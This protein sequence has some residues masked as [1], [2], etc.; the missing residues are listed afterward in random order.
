[1]SLTAIQFTW[2]QYWPSELWIHTLKN[3]NTWCVTLSDAVCGLVI[4]RTLDVWHYEVLWTCMWIGTVSYPLYK[5]TRNC[6]RFHDTWC[7]KTTDLDGRVTII[8]TPLDLSQHPKGCFENKQFWLKE[9]RKK[10]NRY[11]TTQPGGTTQLS[12]STKSQQEH[13]RQKVVKDKVCIFIV[14]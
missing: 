8:N 3:G 4:H 10:V 9:Y 7:G 12:G 13:V 11:D 2:H 6:A 1:M 14:R 5:M